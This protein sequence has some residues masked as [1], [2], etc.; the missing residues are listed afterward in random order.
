MTETPHS[1]PLRARRLARPLVALGL[2]A[3]LAAAG[4]QAASPVVP[5][6][7]SVSLDKLR[8]AYGSAFLQG[9]ATG[10]QG[11]ANLVSNNGAGL[12][13][14]N[15]GS[16]VAP[17]SSRYRALAT[18]RTLDGV[19]E[20]PI[21]NAIVYVTDPDD[22]FFAY[23]GKPLTATTDARG[24]YAF[25]SGLP[26]GQVVI[27][28]VMLSDNRREVG[29]TVSQAGNNTIDV[30]LASTYVTEFLR[31]RAALVGK[32]MGDFD[33]SQ[34]QRLTELTRKALAAGDLATPDL[35]I[36]KIAE[37]NQA[38][39]LAVGLNKQGLGDAWAQVLG[40]RILA[41]TTLAGD[42]DVGADG[43]G[44]LATEAS[45]TK[46]I[47]LA[48]AANGDLFVMDEG[49]HNVRRIDGKTGL[50]STL[51]GNG[52]PTFG[53]DGGP[54]DK[55]NLNWP[56]TGCVGPD[57]ALYVADTVNERIRKVDLAS[58]TITTFA[59]NPD[60]LNGVAANDF[61]GDGGPASQAKL[62]GVRGMAFDSK[63]NLVF[64]DSWETGGHSWDHVRR[65]AKDG[66]I[67]TL[68]GV[69]GARGFNG[70]GKPGRETQ[71]NFLNGL[72]I[73]AQDNVYFAD[74]NNHRVRRIDAKTGLVSTVA[75]TGADGT[76]GDNGPATA[77][78]LSSPYGVAID[79]SGRL[80]I[81][82]RGSRRI[83]M[84]DRDGTIR[85]LAGGGKLAQ[86]G[87]GRA[88]ALNE[89]IDLLLEPSG[90]LLIADSRGARVRRL[91]LQWGL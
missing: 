34:L 33:L 36:G 12:I 52:A 50:I 43:D 85:T 18:R 70:D 9:S 4:C 10:P 81:S 72:A 26:T 67:S 57:G 65:I 88:I 29:Y 82:E 44:K 31:A 45:F 80:F 69:D 39:A 71:L 83:R 23:K 32:K 5:Q 21:A 77:A 11:V 90:N 28:N 79:P 41:V 58:K 46:A 27:V 19:K 54:A 87:E 1:P 7:K 38:Y 8:E 84:V 13:S 55:A 75:G 25:S 15:G 17:Q 66:T 68:A 86:D 6:E 63:G 20:E 89:P 3:L 42:G 47:G 64:T 48:L 49:A 2:A 59:G 56:R 91:W 78:Q 22:K 24:R 40:S 35:S 16:L 30:S 60:M 14:N 37:L 76:A 62:A 73:D 74:T 53:G 61:A 51:A